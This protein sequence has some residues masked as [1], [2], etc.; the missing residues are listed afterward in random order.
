MSRFLFLLA[1]VLSCVGCQSTSGPAETPA[2]AAP[3]GADVAIVTAADAVTSCSF[4]TT[5]AVDPPFPLL[6]RS[7]PEMSFM[8]RDDLQRLLKREAAREGADTVRP[9]GME[10]GKMQGD[11]YSCDS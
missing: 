8:A 10:D 7:Y 11:T 6:T 5:V 4:V 2:A 3:A 1:I 9:L